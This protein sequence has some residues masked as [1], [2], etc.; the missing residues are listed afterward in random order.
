MTPVALV[1][2]PNLPYL[3]GT[4]DTQQF[5]E[6]WRSAPFPDDLE[7]IKKGFHIYGRTH[8]VLAK[9][10]DGRWAVYR[11]KNYGIDWERVWLAGEG[12]IIYDIVL[13]TFGWAIL[14]TSLGF[15]ETTSAGKNWTLVL[16]LPGAPKAPA[17]YN[18]GNGDILMCTDG[19]Y[20]WRSTNIARSWTKILD[21]Q[22]ITHTDG[23][24]YA[25]RYTGPSMACI[26]GA[27]GRV[28]V[29]HGPYILMSENAGLNFAYVPNW[30]WSPSMGAASLRP[31]KAVVCNRMWPMSINP[32][33]LVSQILIS[34]IDGTNGEA[35]VFIIKINDVR[36]VAGFT[37]LFAWTFKSFTSGTKTS[38]NVGINTWWKP[39]FQQYLMPK[40]G[41]CNLTSYDV[42]VM[43]ESRNDKLVF[44]A[45]T[46]IDPTT[47]N[48]IPS[49]KYSTDGGETWTDIDLEKIKIGD[50]DGGGIY[51]GSMMDENFVKITW[52]TAAC[53]NYGWYHSTE[54]YR[55][56][57]QS[58]EMDA[59]LQEPKIIT[60]SMDYMLD[61]KIGE[62]HS[63]SQEVDAILS[64]DIETPYN[65]DY[66]AES[67]HS[68]S[69]LMGRYSEALIAAGY[70]L[71]TINRADA[72]INDM[73]DAIL[74]GKAKKYYHLGL[75]IQGKTSFGYN[76]DAILVKNRLNEK[77]TGIVRDIP[78]F[79]DIDVPDIPYGP[80]DSR[81]E[82]R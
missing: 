17:F 7:N 31:P 6:W 81:T 70:E 66:V 63:K 3:L 11:S 1:S 19:R 2:L 15:Y 35:V 36:P 71:D 25:G 75:L 21:M 72:S 12:E 58:Y 13:I 33:F 40:E 46:R 80:L 79:L 44:S 28:V 38:V 41:E 26:A 27:N 56:Q 74:L 64:E 65:L 34:T 57:C 18:I 49:L 29:A 4:F 78:Q 76:I 77:L 9:R 22:T 68:K 50:P 37:D 53:N 20:I 67:V 52:V 14:N 5:R 61:A 47:G 73:L 45:Q 8:L 39:V 32:G 10:K 30:D 54:L 62:G 60:D 48:P 23:L 16:G 42:A 69:Y 51:G 24:N 59:N 55:R 82:T 43:G